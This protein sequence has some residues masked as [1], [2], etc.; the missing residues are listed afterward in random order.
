MEKRTLHNKLGGFMIPAIPTDK[1]LRST[2]G[3]SLVELTLIVPFMLLLVYGV[4]EVGSVISTYLTLTHTTREGAN[5]TSRGT[6]PNTALDAII[7]SAAPTIR[8]NNFG[9]WRVIYSHLIQNPALPCP[10]KPCTYEVES[11]IIRG[12]LSHGSQIGLVGQTVNIPGIQ[13]VDPNQTFH[14]IEIF[15]DYGPDALTFIGN[16]INKIFY[17]RTIFTNVSSS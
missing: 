14:A 3:Q 10:P 12:S 17:E 5:L 13:D 15:Y 8:N 16:S 6:L 1:M 7:A 4:V 2:S 11:Q 9:Q